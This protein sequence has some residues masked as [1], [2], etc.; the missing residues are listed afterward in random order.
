MALET[1]DRTPRVP[2][3]E[4]EVPFEPSRGTLDYIAQQVGEL[5]DYLRG[6]PED[7]RHDAIEMAL[8]VVAAAYGV[9]PNLDTEP[10]K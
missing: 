8:G 3:E 4:V 5:A 9:K 6:L 2:R 10:G 7:L 1:Q